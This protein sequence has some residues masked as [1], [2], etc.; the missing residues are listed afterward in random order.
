MKLTTLALTLTSALTTFAAPTTTPS[1]LSTRDGNFVFIGHTGALP[2]S[3]ITWQTGDDLCRGDFKTLGAG[4]D[5]NP[6]DIAFEYNG[7]KLAYKQCGVTD[8]ELWTIDGNGAPQ[9]K[10]STCTWD[11]RDHGCSIWEWP[12]Q[13]EWKCEFP[14]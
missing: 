9:T 14:H 11:G 2:I 12:F 10:I 13:I 4:K 3:K 6:C 5:F 1:S 8:P 7:K